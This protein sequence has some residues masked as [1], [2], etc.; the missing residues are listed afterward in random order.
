MK[1]YFDI[2]GMEWTEKE[3]KAEY[4]DYLENWKHEFSYLPKKSYEDF[5]KELLEE[6]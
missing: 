4:E 2:D 5:K 1:T 6:G 3:I